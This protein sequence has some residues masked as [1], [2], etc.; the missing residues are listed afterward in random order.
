MGYLAATK[1][2]IGFLLGSTT[3]L[4]VSGVGPGYV[5]S[6]YFSLF[7]GANTFRAMYSTPTLF[8]V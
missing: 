8:H 4:S 1:N 3:N 2:L 6:P 7:F 5:I